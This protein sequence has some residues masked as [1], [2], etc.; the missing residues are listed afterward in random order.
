MIIT[1][2]KLDAGTWSRTLA[3]GAIAGCAIGLGALAGA[4]TAQADDCEE[5][6]IACGWFSGILNGNAVPIGTN[7]NGNT[8][9]FGA[10]NGNIANGQLNVPILS[11]VIA[12]GNAVNAAPTLGGLAIGGAAASVAADT[13]I[14]VAGAAL[15]LNPA[16]GGIGVG[17]SNLGAALGGLGVGGLGTA[18]A[19]PVALGGL[20]A[21]VTTGT[22]ANVGGT[23]AGVANTAP[24]EGAPTVGVQDNGGDTTAGGGASTANAAANGGD[25][26]GGEADVEQEAGDG[27]GGDAESNG[28]ITRG[29]NATSSG[30]ARSGSANGGTA[31][32]GSARSSANGNAGG[33]QSNNNSSNNTSSNNGNNSSNSVG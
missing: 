29:G 7:G 32:G 28:N 18:A 4:G 13:D 33:N 31:T 27:E 17:G 30:S 3:I 5:S 8:N 25:A 6:G 24:V 11:P 12:G 21:P 22:Q 1:S 9:Q 16:L 26:T 15:G 23:T 14:P 20:A 2:N 10:V 19:I